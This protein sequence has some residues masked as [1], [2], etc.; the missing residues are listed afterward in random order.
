MQVAPRYTLLEIVN[1]VYTDI[2]DT[3][4]TALHCS[5]SRVYSVYLYIL[6]G[7]VRTLLEWADGQNVEVG[8]WMDGVDTP[9]T[10]MTT[11]APAVL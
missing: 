8:D 3:I 11:R 6:L 10:V 5:N 2:V 9:Q 1:T 7:K 4:Q